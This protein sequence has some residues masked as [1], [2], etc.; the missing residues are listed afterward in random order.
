MASVQATAFTSTVC[1]NGSH[2]SRGKLPSS[3]L[4]P[5]FDV[6]GRVSSACKKEICAHSFASG[7]RAT[8][9]FD[10]P[11]KQRKHTAN[12]DSPDF[13]PL[14][15]FEQCFPKSTKEYQYVCF[16]S[17]NYRFVSFVLFMVTVRL[18]FIV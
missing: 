8:L 4:L 5:G 17:L 9:T 11:S 13:L 1:K 14:P 15:S 16:L 12:P 6:A 3:A 10:P 18:K 2:S 7:P